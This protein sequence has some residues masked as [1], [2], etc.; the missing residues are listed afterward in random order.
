M[1]TVNWLQVLGTAEGSQIYQGGRQQLHAVVPLL[2]PFKAEQQSLELVFPRKRPLD[3]HASC[4]D[5]RV[6][7]AFA[8][9]LGGL[10][11]EGMLLA[12]GEQA[13]IKNTRAMVRGVKAA[14]QVE[15]GASEVHA[16]LLG[17][18]RHG[19]QALWE[20]DHVGLLDRRHGD[21]C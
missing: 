10:T 19:F 1:N 7:E 20:Q 13:G 17:S 16:D 2:E 15:I 6:T 8:P 18:L 5:G 14:I 21:G 11:V 12:L 4:V 9:S 3:A